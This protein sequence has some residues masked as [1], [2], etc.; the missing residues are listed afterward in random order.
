MGYVVPEGVVDFE[1][2]A[3][4]TLQEAVAQAAGPSTGVEI[5]THVVRGQPAEVLLNAAKDADLL[6]VG[7]RGRGGFKGLLLGSVSTQCVHHASCPVVVV[8]NTTL[9]TGD[10]ELG[11]I[12][13]RGNGPDSFS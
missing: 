1:E 11:L 9:P 5:R 4:Q 10:D 7:S 8:R 12:Q 2:V 13:P 3:K 6:V